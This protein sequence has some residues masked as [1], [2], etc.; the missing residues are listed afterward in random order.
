LLA[1]ARRQPF[2]LH[3]VPINDVVRGTLGLVSRLLGEAVVVDSRLDDAA[4]AVRV[5]RSRLE[6]V[7]VNLLVNARDAMPDGG[8]ITI[9]TSNEQV[10][11]TEARLHLDAA[12]GNYVVVSVDRLGHGMDAETLAHLFEPFFTTKHEGKGTGLGLATVYGTVRQSGGH[13]RG[14]ARPGEAAAS[15]CGSR[16]PIAR[17]RARPQ[18]GTDRAGAGARRSSS[19]RTSA[20]C[21]S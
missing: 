12:A 8:R 2:E 21:G 16:A 7:L 14:R 5:D 6:Q 20:R 10:T 4:G 13:I 18:R 3:T 1:F 19:S 15:R 9:S 17:T 11:E